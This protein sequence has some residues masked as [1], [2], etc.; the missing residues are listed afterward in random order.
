MGQVQT[1]AMKYSVSEY[2]EMEEQSEIRHEYYDGDVFAMAGTT[3]NHNEIVDNIRSQFKPRFRPVGCRIFSENIKVETIQNLHF[4][5]PDV[6]VTCHPEDIN[7]TYFVRHPRILVE[8]L[9]PSSATLDRDF[10]FRR[11]TKIPS[12]KYYMLVSQHEYF[13][14]LY[15]R[16]EN[17]DIWTYQSFDKP[18][19]EVRFDDDDFAIPVSAIYEGI[20]FDPV[21][22]EDNFP[23]S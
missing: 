23:T 21:E 1:A 11:Y 5:Y 3:M 18:E 22:S 6:V 19:L 15:S 4:T 20:V 2:L 14:E 13:V 17:S 7:G 10:K 8:V 16:T 9:S 12:L